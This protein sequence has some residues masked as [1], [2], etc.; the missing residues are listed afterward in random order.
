MQSEKT[1]VQH[2]YAEYS[3]EICNHTIS[4]AAAAEAEAAN[5]ELRAQLDALQQDLRVSEERAEQHGQRCESL[6]ESLSRMQHEMKGTQQE[7]ADAVAGRSAVAAQR[8]SLEAELCALTASRGELE[9]RLSASSAAAAAEAEAANAELRAQL[10]ALQS[11]L[12]LAV[13]SRDAHAAEVVNL[14]HIRLEESRAALLQIQEA[15]RT[16]QQFSDIF[17]T[18]FCVLQQR[19]ID[20]QHRSK[21]ASEEADKHIAE[22]KVQQKAMQSVLTVN[23]DSAKE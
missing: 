22:L 5:A 1:S 13:Y 7:L 19:L 12:R 17:E 20:E 16:F 18:R 9:Q 3:A 4:A 8:D 21:T 6:E 23:G 14:F 2:G 11:D 10:D 15:S